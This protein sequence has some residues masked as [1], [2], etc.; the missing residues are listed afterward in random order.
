MGTMQALSPSPHLPTSLCPCQ[1]LK[2][3]SGLNRLHGVHAGQQPRCAP[4]TP[5]RGLA[6]L[7]SP[8]TW[9]KI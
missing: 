3:T 9:V 8:E 6:V 4:R 2:V 5:R 7:S 1:P